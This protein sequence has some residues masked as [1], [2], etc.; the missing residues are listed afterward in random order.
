MSWSVTWTGAG[1]SWLSLAR[2]VRLTRTVGVFSGVFGARGIRLLLVVRDPAPDDVSVVDGRASDIFVGPPR[3][4]IAACQAFGS[5]IVADKAPLA[6]LRAIPARGSS[7]F[8][9]NHCAGSH[10]IGVT[11]ACIDP[12]ASP[13]HSTEGAIE[14]QSF[15]AGVPLVQQVSRHGR[16][17]C[18]RNASLEEDV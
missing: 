12:V 8:T 4:R 9:C 18:Y 17:L 6:R 10:E 7:Y 5:R 11:I 3:I 16:H 15:E 13:S 1:A 14:R 2:R